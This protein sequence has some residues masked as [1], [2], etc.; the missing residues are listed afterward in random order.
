MR[1][2]FAIYS[3]EQLPSSFSYPES[4]LALSKDLSPISNIAYFPWWFKD[5]E[6]DL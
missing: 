3:K 2:S 5:L 1:N 4:Y 6:E